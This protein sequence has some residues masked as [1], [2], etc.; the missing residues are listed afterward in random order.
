VARMANGVDLRLSVVCSANGQTWPDYAGG[1]PQQLAS[2]HKVSKLACSPRRRREA[3]V[4]VL[5]P[6]Q[7]C[8]S[9]LHL[10]W[11]SGQRFPTGA[12]HL[13]LLGPPEDLPYPTHATS[14][15]RTTEGALGGTKKDSGALPQPGTKSSVS[16]A[17]V[18]TLYMTLYM[19][20]TS[21]RW[22]SRW[23]RW[24]CCRV[25]QSLQ[26][27][28]AGCA[29]WCWLLS[30]HACLCELRF[31]L[32]LTCLFARCQLWRACSLPV[33]TA[34][35]AHTQPASTGSCGTAAAVL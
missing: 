26:L 33:S 23:A 2:K 25:L 28:C 10:T 9:H 35:L 30:L 4:S 13:R 1:R 5:A 17:L 18:A 34:K 20:A 31:C 21:A 3:A 12:I 22:S 19:T 27:S 6:C 11:R 15:P 16:Q 14:P 32:Q 29:M 24:A 7:Q 8:G